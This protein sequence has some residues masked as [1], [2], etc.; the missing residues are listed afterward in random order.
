MKNKWKQFESVM[1]SGKTIN[2]MIGVLAWLIFILLV[3]L[4]VKGIFHF[5]TM[6]MQ[7]EK[8]AN[9]EPLIENVYLGL[10]LIFWIFISLGL[11]MGM[12]LHG[13]ALVRVS[14]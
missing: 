4:F 13:F 6:P 3:V 7:P 5:T 10:P 8:P 14:K 2:F 1:L 12:A 11:M 9:L